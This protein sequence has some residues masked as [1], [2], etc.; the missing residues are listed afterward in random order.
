MENLEIAK[1][2]QIVNSIRQI[3]QYCYNLTI[4]WRYDFV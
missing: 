2:D 4:F 3:T 1:D